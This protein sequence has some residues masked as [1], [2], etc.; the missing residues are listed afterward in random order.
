MSHEEEEPSWIGR[1]KF[2]V[3]S[4]MTE[5]IEWLI[6]HLGRSTDSQVRPDSGPDLEL[7][8]GVSSPPYKKKM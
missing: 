8:W 1:L 5:G 3:S 7:F 4:A 2:S 6:E